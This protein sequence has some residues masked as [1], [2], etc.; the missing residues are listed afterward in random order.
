VSAIGSTFYFQDSADVRRQLL[1]ILKHH[2]DL[3]LA[4]RAW[5]PL[6]EGGNSTGGHFP[7]PI[8]R[9]MQIGGDIFKEYFANH[10]LQPAHFN[11][12]LFEMKDDILVFLASVIV[13]M[14]ILNYLSILVAEDTL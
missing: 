8:Q 7:L 10:A 5:Q 1:P 3:Q 14:I 13:W 6:D 12:V 9:G 4:G 2:Q 11:A